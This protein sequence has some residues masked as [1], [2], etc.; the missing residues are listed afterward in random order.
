[1]VYKR[2]RVIKKHTRP[3]FGS[4]IMI[5]KRTNVSIFAPVAKKPVAAFWGDKD[6]DGVYNALDCAPNNRKKQGPMHVKDVM[7]MNSDF[8]DR[9]IGAL[10]Q[11]AKDTDAQSE[12][13][14][15]G[16]EEM[17]ADISD[18]NRRH[19]ARKSRYA[20]EVDR[21]SDTFTAKMSRYADSADRASAAHVLR[22]QRVADSADEASLDYIDRKWGKLSPKQ[23][24][25][26]DQD[27]S[28]Y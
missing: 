18:I 21:A 11:Q 15:V 28:T 1:M 12:R 16:K 14:M 25:I 24:Q 2:Y 5:P 23:R 19:M 10:K 13:Y 7:R 8:M 4:A 17:A 20:A 9:R 6:G 22:R 27:M 26:A 3:L